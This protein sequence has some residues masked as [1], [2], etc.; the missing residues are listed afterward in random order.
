MKRILFAWELGSGLGH[1]NRLCTIANALAQ[2]GAEPVFITAD[3]AA[4]AKVAARILPAAPVI[5]NER[6]LATRDRNPTATPTHTIADILW[7]LGGDSPE[8]MAAR[9]A[10]WRQQIAQWKP[11][12]IVADSAPMALAAAAGRVP[13]IAVGNAFSIPPL[14]PALPPIR[15]WEASVPDLSRQRETLLL[16]TLEGV[17]IAGPA[18]RQFGIS[19]LYHGTRTHIGSLPA[20]DPYRSRAARKIDAP[21]NLTLQAPSPRPHAEDSPRLAY[22]YLVD[23][24]R[25]SWYR[26]AD[27]FRK[28]GLKASIYAPRIATALK[29]DFAAAGNEILDAPIDY[30]AILPKVHVFVHQGGVGG[31]IAALHYGT[32]QLVLS[33]NLE[34]LINAR[35]VTG[36]RAGAGL[37]IKEADDP[38]VLERAL[39]QALVERADPSRWHVDLEAVRARL[40]SDSLGAIV[41]SANALM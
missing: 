41:R 29:H 7:L 25:P 5:P 26:L 33:S 13:T 20:F 24:E 38:A 31:C 3:H 19:S 37:S 4:T 22:V 40:A 21:V 10:F 1:V 36:L 35:G 27:L 28:Y 30:G 16:R 17:G 12:L 15:P 39:A 18:W 6:W 14:L 23:R 32:P 34:N 2:A 8:R 11:S 9:L